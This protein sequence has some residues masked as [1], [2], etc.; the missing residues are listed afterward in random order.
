[1]LHRVA[2][3]LVLAGSLLLLTSCGSGKGDRNRPVL[4]AT[5]PAQSQIVPNVVE[6][7][8]VLY[9]DEIEILNPNVVW[10][11]D[12]RGQVRVSAYVDPIDRRILRIR[13]NAGTSFLPGRTEI[14]VGAGLVV[15]QLQQYDTQDFVFWFECGEGPN[16]FV[17]NQGPNVV[18][19]VS[20]ETF[21]G[22]ATTPTPGGRAP[23]GVTA[24]Q[25]GSDIRIWTQLEDGGGLGRSVA[26]FGP[27]D[28]SMSEVDLAHE[29]GGDLVCAYDAIDLSRDG[30]LVFAAFRDTALQQVRVT[31]IDIDSA[32]EVRTLVLS[33]PSSAATEPVGLRSGPL[34][35][36]LFVTCASTSGDTLHRIDIRRWEEDDIGS[37]PGQDGQ[38]LASGAGALATWGV[39][40]YTGP[41]QSTTSL[42]SLATPALGGGT[43]LDSV[44]D[45]VGRPT[46]V[47]ITVDGRW[48]M[49]SLEGYEGLDGLV[50]RNLVSPSS[51]TP[52]P[53]E[54][55]T[56][57]GGSAPTSATALVPYRTELRFALLLDSG[58]LATYR[59]SLTE[60]TQDDLDPAVDGIQAADISDVA[61]HPVDGTFVSGIYLR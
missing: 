27:E 5:F 7:V 3:L 14:I 13:T 32:T 46:A 22:I 33:A 15:N 40:A 8:A 34:G 19:E 44:S 51:P 28:G 42:V 12:R 4:L 36:Y 53:V 45:I 9:D 35:T 31:A 61:P 26:W 52:V 6:E 18:A 60:V 29:P 11:I 47:L 2:S 54:F 16:L 37:Q 10:M 59:W 1:M 21:A 30:R 49:E 56:G 25:V 55:D 24:V 43:V 23:V 41:R 57:A 17:A 48:L 38:S 50:R 58:A 20:R 39:L